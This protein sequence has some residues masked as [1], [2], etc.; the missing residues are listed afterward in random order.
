ME[1]TAE[2]RAWLSG[3]AGPILQKALRTLIRYG[4]VFGATRLVPVTSSHFVTPPGATFIP[5]MQELLHDMVTAGVKLKVPMTINPRPYEPGEGSPM[6]ERLYGWREKAEGLLFDLGLVDSFTCTPYYGTN[7]PKRGDILGWAESSAVVYA[8]SVLGARTNRNSAMVE[9][10]SA[11]TGKTPEFGLLLDENRRGT[12][13]VRL[14]LDKEPPYSLLGYLIGRR[15]GSRVPVLDYLPATEADLKDLG[16]AAASAGAVGLF[17][18]LGLTPEARE[19]SEGVLAPKYETM[20][21]TEQD[22]AQLKAE[23]CRPGT[24][25]LIIIGCPHLSLAQLTSWAQRLRGRRVVTKTWFITSPHVTAEFEATPAYQDLKASGA[26]IKHFCPLAYLQI[27][28]NGQLKVLTDSGKL[29]YY[30]QASYAPAEV[31]LAAMLGQTEG[32]VS[33]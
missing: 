30:T 15:V 17:H 6:T 14:E 25:E 11:L 28:P 7:V 9:L 23:L 18:V 24:P 33:A 13:R 27:P 29:R 19:F 5:T 26:E 4:E 22:L 2:E 21:I 20:T 32:G 1:L 3:A 16:A 8:N 31:C 12:V 10:C